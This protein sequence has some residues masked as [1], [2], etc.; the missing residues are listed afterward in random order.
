MEKLAFLVNDTDDAKSVVATLNAAGVENMAISVIAREGTPLDELPTS[1]PEDDSDVMPA[2]ARG[3]AAGGA[4]GLL[5]GI[6][7]MVFPPAGIVVGGAAVLASTLGG[8]SFGAFASALVGAS[9]P[10]SQ[11]R[12]YESAVQAGKILMVVEVEEER[13]DDTRAILE[14]A[15]AHV[16]AISIKDDIPPAL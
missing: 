4:T 7:A 3:I 1:D 11:L 13:V 2:F 6:A 10:N 8:A 16:Q 12:E 14:S 9:V 15:H 5:A